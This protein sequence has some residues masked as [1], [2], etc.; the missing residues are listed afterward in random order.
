VGGAREGSAAW[1]VDEWSRGGLAAWAARLVGGWSTGNARLGLGELRRRRRS[2]RRHPSPRPPPLPPE[3][4]NT[5]APN[6]PPP[7][8][9]LHEPSQPEVR[10]GIGRYRPPLSVPPSPG[11]HRAREDRRPPR[12]EPPLPPVPLFWAE[13]GRRRRFCLSPVPL[14]SFPH[15]DPSTP[16][17]FSF[18]RPEAPD[19]RGKHY[20]FLQ[21]FV[22][23]NYFLKS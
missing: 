5:T 15:W 1:L 3:L 13:G 20:L 2:S 22:T 16:S 18:A 21:N 23:H 10:T 12:S 17:L 6:H 7:S 9:R 14:F 11:C 8:I 19:T 4:P